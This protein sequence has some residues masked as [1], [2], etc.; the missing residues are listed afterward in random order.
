M[1]IWR[2]VPEVRRELYAEAAEE[3]MRGQK[4]RAREI[5]AVV[6]ESLKTLGDDVEIE[7]EE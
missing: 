3:D 7:W 5:E 6:D 2:P 1:L 4:K